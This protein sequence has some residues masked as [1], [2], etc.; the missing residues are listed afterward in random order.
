ME[1]EL[2]HIHHGD[3]RKKIDT[4]VPAGRN[5]VEKLL[6]NLCEQKCAV[7][8]ERGKETYR[9]IG[10]DKHADKLVVE[11]TRRR[12]GKKRI[13]RVTMADAKATC[14]VAAA[15]A[16]VAAVAPVAGG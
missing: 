5:E 13:E 16:K 14:R 1:V 8:L 10:Y 12:K 2:L 4:S 9:V 11:I 6:S 15:D 3:K 7:F